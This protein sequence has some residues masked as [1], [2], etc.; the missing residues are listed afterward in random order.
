MAC[1]EIEE[2]LDVA[3]GVQSTDFSRVFRIHKIPIKVGILN[4]V[5][6]LRTPHSELVDGDCYSAWAERI[7][8]LLVE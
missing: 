3:S 8:E 2:S 5:S 7:S 4:A 6:R 1:E